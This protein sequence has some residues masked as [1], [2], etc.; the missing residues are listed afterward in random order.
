VGG[1]RAEEKLGTLDC[2]VWVQALAE[3]IVTSQNTRGVGGG[4]T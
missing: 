3:A 2:E 4:G 1:G